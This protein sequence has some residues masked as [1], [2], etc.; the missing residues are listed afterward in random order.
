MHCLCLLP[1]TTIPIPQSAPD[2]L[3]AVFRSCLVRFILEVS[4]GG[5]VLWGC[6]FGFLALVDALFF[7]QATRKIKPRY[8]NPPECC[9][10]A[11]Q[12][13]FN[14][15]INILYVFQANINYI[16]LQPTAVFRV[17]GW[18]GKES[19]SSLRLERHM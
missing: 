2:Y 9:I 11:A 13:S 7:K 17:L 15:S 18:G 10:T 19:K 12:E 5:C 3:A 1:L 16:I 14:Q 4:W 8:W 6:L